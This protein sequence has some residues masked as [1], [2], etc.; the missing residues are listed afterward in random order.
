MKNIACL[1][2]RLIHLSRHYRRRLMQT[3]RMLNLVNENQIED[4][5]ANYSDRADALR[6]QRMQETDSEAGSLTGKLEYHSSH[7]SNAFSVSFTSEPNGQLRLD[8]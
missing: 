3:E 5:C 4:R 8:A 2:A 6:L 1:A 7:E